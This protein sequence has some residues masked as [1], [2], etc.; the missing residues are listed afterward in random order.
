MPFEL[1]VIS[2][3]MDQQMIGNKAGDTR[4]FRERVRKPKEL[5]K[6]KETKSKR[7]SVSEQSILGL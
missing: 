7:V 6:A 3:M 4:S 1:A 5:E 2:H